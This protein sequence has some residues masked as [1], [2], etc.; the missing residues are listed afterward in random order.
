M[1]RTP[2]RRQPILQWAADEEQDRADEL[3]LGRVGLPEPAHA[4]NGAELVDMSHCVIG[5]GRCGGV[6]GGDGLVVR[7][8][9]QRGSCP[10]KRCICKRKGERS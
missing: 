1:S 7:N 8:G 5:C 2:T 10:T 9:V 3:A 4:L 6:Y